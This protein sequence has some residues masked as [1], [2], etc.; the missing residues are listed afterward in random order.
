M[1]PL[2]T[3][4]SAERAERE[5]AERA[6]KANEMKSVRQMAT[7]LVRTR[8]YITKFYGM[9]SQ[10]QAVQLKLEVARTTEAMTSAMTKASA[11]P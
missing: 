5:K 6:A 3:G 1:A 2:R 10:L 8:Q 11:A 7:D 4:P 9:R